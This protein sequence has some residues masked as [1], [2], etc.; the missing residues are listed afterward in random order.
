MN[1]SLRLTWLLAIV[2]LR[3]KIPRYL[4]NKVV[5]ERN[6]IISLYE[7][8]LSSFACKHCFMVLMF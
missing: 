2:A 8:S 5:K 6:K 3:Y 7:S 4:P 1:A